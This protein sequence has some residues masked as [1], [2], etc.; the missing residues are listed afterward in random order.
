MT[1]LQVNI[2]TLYYYYN[3]YT[4]ITGLDLEILTTGI[5]AGNSYLSDSTLRIPRTVTIRQDTSSFSLGGYGTIIMD[6]MWISKQF[7]SN[8][9]N[10]LGTG[11]WIFT[12]SYF[13]ISGNTN[14]VG[15]INLTNSSLRISGS[16]PHTFSRILGTGTSFL[17]ADCENFTAT[18]VTIPSFTDSTY[19]YSDITN[20]KFTNY[21]S[22]SGGIKYLKSGTIDSVYAYQGYY[23]LIL[24]QIEV[25]TLTTQLGSTVAVEAVTVINNFKFYGGTIWQLDSSGIFKVTNTT[26]LGSNSLKGFHNTTVL[27]TTY[28]DC[29]QC[30]SPDCAIPL[31]EWSH[32]QYTTSS[33]GCLI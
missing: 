1:K 19:R 25:Q 9:V 10:M 18:E 22:T 29:N 20:A 30:V 32:I 11:T 24:D 4:G 23:R 3:H 27:I 33:F 16:G 2:L 7:Y 12:E 14:F 21:E 8:D 26:Y 15:D 28:L 17:E 6:G 13:S 31:N 5:F